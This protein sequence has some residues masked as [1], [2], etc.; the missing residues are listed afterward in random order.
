MPARASV[1]RS[2]GRRSAPSIDVVILTP[3]GR[4]L[5]VLLERAPSG[6]RERWELPWRSLRP[7]ETI[8]DEAAGLSRNTL[9]TAPSLIEQAGAF[10]DG[11]RHPSGGALS[12]AFLALV[13]RETGEDVKGDAAWHPVDDLPPLPPRQRTNESQQPLSCRQTWPTALIASPSTPLMVRTEQATSS[14]YP[15]PKPARLPEETGSHLSA[16][17]FYRVICS[18]GCRGRNFVPSLINTIV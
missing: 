7:N 18:P 6:S 2:K 1:A 15:L 13:D 12:V 17:F 14:V 5:M 9:G 16:H 3:R 4:R 11:R 10:G 8:D